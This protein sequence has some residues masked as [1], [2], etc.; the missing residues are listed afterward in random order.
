MARTAAVT[1]GEPPLFSRTHASMGGGGQSAAG[2]PGSSCGLVS[3]RANGRVLAPRASRY[4]EA[5]EPAPAHPRLRRHARVRKTV[6]DTRRL[7][8][9]R[10]RAGWSRQQIACIAVGDEEAA[11]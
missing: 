2:R 6:R 3:E 9:A 7:P 8:L 11:R 1:G 4:G 10:R 5:G